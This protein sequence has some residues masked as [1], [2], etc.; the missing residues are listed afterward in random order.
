LADGAALGAVGA[1]SGGLAIGTADW[2]GIAPA[3]GA[4]A[5]IGGA[6]GLGKDIISRIA[7]FIR[8]LS[9]YW[10]SKVSHMRRASSNLP[11]AFKK[12][13]WARSASGALKL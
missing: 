2:D 12:W 4:V 1:A 13:T 3:A 9:R 11:F 6:A 10:L 7:S 8:A 5:G